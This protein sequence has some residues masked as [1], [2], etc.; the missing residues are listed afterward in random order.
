MRVLFV[1][2]QPGH[3]Q[4]FGVMMLSAVLKKSGHSVGLV[5]LS[6]ARI[7][8]ELNKAKW[9]ILAFSVS[10]ASYAQAI[11]ICREIRKKYN[12]C[13]IFGGPHA[14][15]SPEIIE[16]P[17]IDAVCR[18]EGE[19]ALLEFLERK[20]AE[21]TVSDVK[22]WWVKEDGR[23]FKNDVRP[24]IEHLDSL[25]FAD[26]KIAEG[27]NFFTPDM[28]E[29]LISRGCLFNCSYCFNEKYFE[30]YRQKGKRIRTRSL[31]NIFEELRLIKKVYSPQRIA[32]FD[33]I[34]PS[35]NEWN[36]EFCR[37]YER[38]IGIPFSAE[39]RP[40]HLTEEMVRDL[41]KAGCHALLIGIESVN[42]KIRQE[43][44]NRHMSNSVIEECCRMIK[45]YGISICAF[46]LCGLPNSTIEDDLGT[47][48]FAKKLR[49]DVPLV[50]ACQ[51][52]PKTTMYEVSVK[53][54]WLDPDYKIESADLL[55]CRRSPFI[56]PKKNQNGQVYNLV[57]LYGIALDLKL[58]VN[59]IRSLIKLPISPVY[60]FVLKFWLGFLRVLQR[61]K[62]SV[63][64]FMKY[65]LTTY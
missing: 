50:N 60:F 35:S 19:F 56:F 57:C 40:E 62:V 22:N 65:L 58:S 20:R 23:I 15:F 31:D 46:I 59:L 8:R 37:R 27:F 2:P 7:A 53:R 25:P 12:I 42:E 3:T 45:S 24:L 61:R 51:P 4:P 26:R 43:L 29:V 16:E 38:E 39:S 63:M 47:L 44:L 33:D 14:T 30:L 55:S 41:K 49:V 52:Y 28:Q 6:R 32:I 21:K 34:F 64:N 1:A 36:K 11:A 18:G 17:C 54:G 10:T 5:S 9:D 48:A 13:T